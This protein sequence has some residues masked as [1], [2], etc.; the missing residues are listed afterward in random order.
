M[1]LNE[2]LFWGS[3]VAIVFITRD[4]LRSVIKTEQTVQRNIPQL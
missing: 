4:H 1:I 3:R 2:R